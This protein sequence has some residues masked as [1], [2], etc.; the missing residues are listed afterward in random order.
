MLPA[1][2]NVQPG[3]LTVGPQSRVDGAGEWLGSVEQV[4]QELGTFFWL[5]A[6]G[7]QANA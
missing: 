7:Y 6:R 5:V 3:S 1:P 4:N 2:G